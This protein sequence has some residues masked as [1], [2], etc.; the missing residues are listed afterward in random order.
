MS[1]AVPWPH[2]PQGILTCQTCGWIV[3]R[4][5]LGQCMAAGLDLWGHIVRCCLMLLSF[6][7][8]PMILWLLTGGVL[9]VVFLSLPRWDHAAGDQAPA[10]CRHHRAAASAVCPAL[11]YVARPQSPR[12]I[13][14]SLTKTGRYSSSSP[15][16]KEKIWEWQ[17]NHILVRGD[18]IYFTVIQNSTM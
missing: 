17:N 18:H 10:C 4:W 9:P 8:I 13:P 6:L 3:H 12:L 2:F 14:A 11:R 1:R 7:Y 5:W 16:V 15:F